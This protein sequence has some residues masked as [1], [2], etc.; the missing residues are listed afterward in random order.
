MRLELCGSL[1]LTIGVR[2]VKMNDFLVIKNN[3]IEGL[4]GDIYKE[5][6]GVSD[7]KK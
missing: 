4:T 5:Y 1:N 2:E 7:H 3:Q 6:Y